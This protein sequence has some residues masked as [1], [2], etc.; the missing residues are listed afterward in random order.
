MDTAHFYA[1]SRYWLDSA[2]LLFRNLGCLAY[3]LGKK[4]RVR[5][6]IFVAINEGVLHD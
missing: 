5:A 4:Y 2:C 1:E 6:E 3:Q